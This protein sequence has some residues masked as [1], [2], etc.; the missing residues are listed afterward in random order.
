[1]RVNYHTHTQRCGHA[2]GTEADYV[3]AAIQ[4]GVSVL[5]FTDHCPLPDWEGISC[6]RMPMAELPAYFAAVEEE[7]RKHA[8]E[9]R[10]LK[11]VEVEYMPQYRDFLERLYTD[12]H[13]DYL[14]LGQHFFDHRGT[15]A[16]VSSTQD[17]ELLPVYA[18]SIREALRTGLF[19]IV[20]HPDLFG[21]R[22]YPWDRNCDLARDIILDAA[23][24][25]GAVL[26]W[27]ANGIR[28]GV[29]SFPDGDRVPYPHPR[30]WDPVPGSGIPVVVG[31]DCHSPDILWDDAVEQ[32]YQTLQ[33]MGIAP[34]SAL[35]LG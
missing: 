19:Q 7:A 12:H 13:V 24:E 17:T 4:A 26:E 1:M 11:S 5:G 20:A 25:T 31:S 9:I 14:L 23:A 34:I 32:S 35:D 10:I 22:Q 33:S 6:F 3:Q 16:F 2:G 18:R 30:F 28:R 27:N 21:M 8:R 29:Q 15:R